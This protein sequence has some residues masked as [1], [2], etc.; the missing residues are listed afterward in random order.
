MAFLLKRDYNNILTTL[1]L[2]LYTTIT[3]DLCKQSASRV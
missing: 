1:Y 2:R 3:N